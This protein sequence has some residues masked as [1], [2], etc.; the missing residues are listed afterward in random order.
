MWFDSVLFEVVDRRR[1]CLLCLGDGLEDYR[2]GD[3]SIVLMELFGYAEVLR[4]VSRKVSRKV[5]EV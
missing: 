5:S 1:H 3:A 4:E 2:V